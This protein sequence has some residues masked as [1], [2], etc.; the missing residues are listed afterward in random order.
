[1]KK[2]LAPVLAAI[3]CFAIAAGFTHQALSAAT[4]NEKDTKAEQTKGWEGIDRF[5]VEAVKAFIARQPKGD[6]ANTIKDRLALMEKMEA[7]DS[8]KLSPVTIPFS[9]LAPWVGKWAEAN[10]EKTVI[11]YLA[12]KSGNNTVYKV[13]AT[14]A[15]PFA[16]TIMRRGF[17]CPPMGR[18]TIIAFRT[19]G[20]KFTWPE[21][22][23]FVS[24]ADS[25]LFFGV[26]PRKGGLI[27]LKGKG[28][29]TALDNK[30]VSLHAK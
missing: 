28:K 27:F 7:I 26:L 25:T 21:G 10:T 12:E 18:G 29:F 11:L 16:Q 1:M 2:H 19:N 20:L 13:G 4:E 22:G 5:S 3:A 9:I 30:E 24:E 23:T 15:E 6:I 17:M 14:L 8:G